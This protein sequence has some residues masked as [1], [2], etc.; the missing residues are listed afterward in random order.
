VGSGNPPTETWGPGNIYLTG[1]VTVPTGV[2]LVINPGTTIKAQPLAD[3]RLSGN[4]PSRIEVIV[5]GTLQSNGAALDRVLL[6]SARPVPPG[7]PP[8]WTPPRRDWRGLR[9]A[10]TSDDAQNLL[11]STDV[12][13]GWNGIEFDGGA[14]ALDDVTS[15]GSFAAGLNLKPGTQSALPALQVTGGS[16]SRNGGNR[17]GVS[18]F[19]NSTP[20]SFTFEQ[21]VVEENYG[22][23]IG[24]NGLN[25]PASAVLERIQMRGNRGWGMADTSTDITEFRL[26]GSVI[27][28]NYLGGFRVYPR[29]AAI[30]GNQFILNRGPA[31]GMSV[32]QRFQERRLVC[33]EEPL[34]HE[35]LE[36]IRRDEPPDDRVSPTTAS[37]PTYSLTASNISSASTIVPHLH[38]HFNSVLA[39]AS[40]RQLSLGSGFGFD[41]RRN[42]WGDETTNRDGAAVPPKT[43][44][45]YTTRWTIQLSDSS[46]TGTT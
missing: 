32:P 4:D 38:L 5:A 20:P 15:E 13:A 29:T 2:R 10:D 36:P 22:D 16:F 41:A 39:A 3:D 11:R 26:I 7:A 24:G 17:S 19:S 12:R 30:H 37:R 1:D 46:T 14:S 42:W 21:T 23:G 44:R 33:H 25:G 18:T 40:G 8:D 43:S 35:R 34:R 6:T 27:E 28:N 31:L 9:F 45:P